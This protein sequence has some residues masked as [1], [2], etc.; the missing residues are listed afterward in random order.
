MQHDRKTS[1][2]VI[3]IDGPSGVG[4]GTISGLLA[5][6]L[7]WQLLDSGA[8]YRLLALAAVSQQVALD[9]ESALFRLAQELYCEFL[10]RDG[11]ACILLYGRE[12]TTEIRSETCGN[13]ASRIAAL[14]K[15]REA[16]LAWQRVFRKPPGLVAD[17]RDMGTKIFPDAELKIFLTASAY[18]R[19][20]RRHK[21]LK[22]QGTDV[23]LASLLTEINERDQRDR[24]RTISPLGPAADAVII[25]TTKL[26][27]EAVL[28]CVTNVVTVRGIG[29]KR[30]AI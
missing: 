8:L 11:N 14:I 7:G 21:Q 10:H 15:V 28:D 6:R 9:D 4:K 30:V 12:V 5:S 24:E 20:E 2:P 26:D 1:V 17:G 3:T 13:N 18:E 23:N 22:A 25:D 19:A 27:I 16:L 29:D